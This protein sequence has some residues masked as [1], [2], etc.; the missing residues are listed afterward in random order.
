MTTLFYTIYNF[1][2]HSNNRSQKRE[3]RKKAWGILNCLEL[4]FPAHF[5]P[6]T[7]P[8]FSHRWQFC[9]YPAISF[10]LRCDKCLQLLMRHAKLS[11][12]VTVHNPVNI[13]IWQE[14]LQFWIWVNALQFPW[15]WCEVAPFELQRL[16]HL[17]HGNH[18]PGWRHRLSFKV[19]VCSR[20][21]IR[22]PISQDQSDLWVIALR[23]HDCGQLQRFRGKCLE[24]TNGLD[25]RPFGAL[26]W[27][28]RMDAKTHVGSKQVSGSI[29]WSLNT[30]TDTFLGSPCPP[31]LSLPRVPATFVVKLLSTN[32]SDWFEPI[33][34]HWNERAV[35]EHLGVGR[36]LHL[37]SSHPKNGAP[38]RLW[39][40]SKFRGRGAKNW[41][42]TATFSTVFTY[43]R[44]FRFYAHI[45]CCLHIF[46]HVFETGWCKAVLTI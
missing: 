29:E 36:A 37:Q 18:H 4:S 16:P 31:S 38:M 39:N 21:R 41:I 33:T 2:V 14:L 8:N 43:F 12:P 1:H 45:A 9:N 13:E 10:E 30:C 6:G 7:F 35:L 46:R 27:H 23:V 24:T 20:R 42:H 11:I 40:I 17:L 32:R 15:P 25:P 19:V 44:F 3:P 34:A 22:S 28:G 26:S 5:R